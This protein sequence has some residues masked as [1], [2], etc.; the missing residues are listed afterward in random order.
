M[1]Y[2]KYKF[3]CQ[4]ET[5]TY[6]PDYHGSTLRGAFGHSLKKIVCTL[7]LK[8]CK[9]CILNKQCLY[10]FFFETKYSFDIKDNINNASPPP[11]PY[12]IE[13]QLTNKNIFSKG[14][15]FN[16]DLIFFGNANNHLPYIIYAIEQIGKNGIGKK[17]NDNYGKFFL[18]NVIYDENTI[19]SDNDNEINIPTPK[20]LLYNSNSN[21]M[22][23]NNSKIHV[24]L[25]TPLRI[26]FKNQFNNELP[27]HVLVRA[28]LRRVSSLL[29]YYG[30]GEPDINYKQ[31]IQNAQNVKTEK[32]NIKWFDWRRYSNKQKE[33]MFFGGLLGDVIYEG[34]L[35]EFIPLFEFCQKT[36]IGKQTTFGLGKI[37][38]KILK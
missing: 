6:L 31:L 3:M 36:H 25:D 32:S 27:F 35:S 38:F 7:T 30:D 20:K 37:H 26:K 17:I 4:M 10:S 13:P 19:Y 11:N 2:A 22:L 5:E 18:K 28:M 16:F 8:E 14:D 23:N 24:F 1:Q 21:I 9:K 34:N 29:N 33:K 12:V 15:D